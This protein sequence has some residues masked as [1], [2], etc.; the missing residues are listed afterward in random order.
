MAGAEL[1]SPTP[2]SACPEPHSSPRAVPTP[3]AH[4]HRHQHEV[5]AP[6]TPLP[7][8]GTL[9]L[10]GT[11]LQRVP[12]GHGSAA[13]CLS[14]RQTQHTQG[15]V[16][17]TRMETTIPQES[18]TRCFTFCINS[19]N[20]MPGERKNC[21]SGPHRTPCFGAKNQN[22]LI[23]CSTEVKP[24][25]VRRSINSPSTALSV[26]GKAPWLGV[27]KEITQQAQDKEF[28][29]CTGISALFTQM[30]ST[31]LPRAA[32]ILLLRGFIGFL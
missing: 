13:S 17:Q 19:E 22:P 10:E 2:H 18:S 5:T 29:W 26:H 9:C 6:K 30:K 32:I 16:L 24:S 23:R 27:T 14:P 11:R 12:R 1:L 15:N 31:E 7:A 20:F 25:V 21:K 28:W 4:G 8:Q 3:Q